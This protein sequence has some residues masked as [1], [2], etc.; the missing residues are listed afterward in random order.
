[1]D[2]NRAIKDTKDICALFRSSFDV[3]VSLLISPTILSHDD[4]VDF[5]TAG[6][7]KIGVAI[8]LATPELFDT[9]R[10]SGVGGL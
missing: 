8:D 4:L 1:L 7:D 3:P 9:Y 10:G 2:S 6:A 5:K